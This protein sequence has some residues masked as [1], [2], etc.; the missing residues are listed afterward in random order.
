MNSFYQTNNHKLDLTQALFYRQ[1]KK[2]KINVDIGVPMPYLVF[3]VV[4]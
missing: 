1:K 2:S 3:I 4:L